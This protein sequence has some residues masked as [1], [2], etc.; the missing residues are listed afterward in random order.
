M[1]PAPLAA[2]ALPVAPAADRRLPGPRPLCASPRAGAD[3]EK[4]VS[5]DSAVTGLARARRGAAGGDGG[6]LSLD[7]A[8]LIL[9]LVPLEPLPPHAPTAPPPRAPR[10]ANQA[11]APS[12]TAG[13]AR[14]IAERGSGAAL[15]LTP[16]PSTVDTPDPSPLAGWFCLRPGWRLGRV[17]PP[18][19]SPPNPLSSPQPP[20][21]RTSPEQACVQRHQT[22]PLSHC[23]HAISRAFPRPRQCA[24]PARWP[25]DA[26]AARLKCLPPRQVPRARRR[27]AARTRPACPR[28][29]ER[30]AAGLAAWQGRQGRG[31]L[32]AR[33]LRARPRP[34]S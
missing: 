6:G 28:G 26:A 14:R 20:G 19:V 17:L 25:D 30:L 31:S 24:L 3:S 8:Q 4:C 21:I 23:P 29:D 2:P 7:V 27:R 16:P 5:S 10:T 18:R 15:P 34:R 9:A 11:S 33:L 1:T 22:Q 13:S 12:A 32:Y